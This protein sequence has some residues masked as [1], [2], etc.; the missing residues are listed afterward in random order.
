MEIV[1]IKK[2]KSQGLQLELTYGKLYKVL[3]FPFGAEGLPY[4]ENNY[5]IVNDRNQTEYYSK[6]DFVTIDEWR[7]LKL[8]EV[9]I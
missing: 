1:C 7:E 5:S 4:T 8:E 2:Y 6:G 9:G 3:P